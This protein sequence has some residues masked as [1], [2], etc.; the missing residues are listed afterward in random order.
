[1]FTSRDIK[2]S[3]ITLQTKIKS[4]RIISLDLSACWMLMR[5]LSS[6]KA[7]WMGKDGGSWAAAIGSG[8]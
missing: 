4:G 1:M 5:M 3:E 6:W 2:S 7:F 8:G